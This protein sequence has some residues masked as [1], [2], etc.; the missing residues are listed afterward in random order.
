MKRLFEGLN[1]KTADLVL[2]V[3]ASQ[4]IE[5]IP[6]PR[7]K[8]TF[9]LLVRDRDLEAAR[10]HLDRYARENPLPGATALPPE[11][12]APFFSPSA[13]AA[14]LMLACVHLVLVRSHLWSDALFAYGASPYFLGQG[15][16]FRAITALFLHSDA[17]HLMGNMAGIILLAGPLT[18]ITGPGTGLFFLLAAATAGNLI[19]NSLAMDTRL[20]IGAS[21]AVMAA[22]GLLS[23]RQALT[24][25]PRIAFW[26]PLAAGLIL[27]AL[28]SHGPRTDVSAH[29]FGFLAGAGTGSIVF[30][31]FRV[32][33]RPW[34]EPFC[35]IL[36]LLISGAAVLAGLHRM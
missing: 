36:V 7:G 2:T 18:R 28:F 9:D 32:W 35:L 29:V 33:H 10:Y 23:A 17:G 30:P 3:L 6:E 13:V 5:G 21:T 20:S 22:A 34:M 8:S 27:T 1:R 15:E 12:T 16:T 11:T 25:L 31:L 24:R 4:N 19:S 26:Q 14:A